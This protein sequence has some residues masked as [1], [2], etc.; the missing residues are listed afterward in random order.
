MSIPFARL[1]ARLAVVCLVI[2]CSLATVFVRRAAAGTSEG[3]VHSSA[4]MTEVVAAKPDGSMRGHYG[5]APMTLRFEGRGLLAYPPSASAASDPL[6]VVYL[7]GVHGRAENGCP[8]FRGGASELGWLVC[9]EGV[10]H[11]ASGAASWGGDVFAQGAVVTHALRAARERGAS[12][13]PG[14]AVG[15]SQGGYVALDLVKTRQARF[16]GLVLIAAPEAHPSARKLRD[17]GVERVA[18]A[19]GSEDAAYAPLVEDAKR[20]QRE[21]MDARFFDLGRVGHTYAAEETE[22]LREAIAWAGGIRE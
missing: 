15:F 11:E 16:R 17:A 14:V 22:T 8:W 3:A 12:S 6:T 21:G 19:A 1:A 7:H 13:E 5:A 2:A 10:A 20:L 18:L 4:R 9:P